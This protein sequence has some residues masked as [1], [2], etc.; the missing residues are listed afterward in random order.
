MGR[1]S[2]PLAAPQI[3]LCPGVGGC[4]VWGAHTKFD[5]QQNGSGRACSACVPA[6]ADGGNDDNKTINYCMVM[7]EARVCD[8]MVQSCLRALSTRTRTS[9]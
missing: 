4:H 9:S 3:I 8:G 6:C 2:E 5:L 1:Q 7:D